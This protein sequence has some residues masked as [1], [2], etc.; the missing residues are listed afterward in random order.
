[1]E[2]PN[3]RTKQMA[4]VI[5]RIRW[6]GSQDVMKTNY[7]LTVRLALSVGIIKNNSSHI[8]LAM[9]SEEKPV[10]VCFNKNT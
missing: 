5:C 3:I 2:F 6:R 1:M 10:S 9:S 7:F 8:I 4:R